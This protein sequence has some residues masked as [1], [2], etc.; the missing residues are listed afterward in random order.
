MNGSLKFLIVSAFA[1]LPVLNS[2][3]ANDFSGN[4]VIPAKSKDVSVSIGTLLSDGTITFESECEDCELNIVGSSKD[5]EGAVIIKEN[6]DITIAIGDSF[7]TTGKVVI[8][9]DSKVNIT[10][11]TDFRGTIIVGAGSKV[12]VT[13]LGDKT[14]GKFQ[15]SPGGKAF[16]NGRPVK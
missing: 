2:A 3:S 9:K 16:L 10:C 5:L 6:C 11:G 12:K 1:V 7:D 15:V 14:D 13:T 4:K 8:G